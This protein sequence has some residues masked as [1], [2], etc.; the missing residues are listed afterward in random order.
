MQTPAWALDAVLQDKKMNLYNLIKGNKIKTDDT[1]EVKCKYSDDMILIP[2]SGKFEVID[3]KSEA[4]KAISDCQSLDIVERINII[5]RAAD[6]FRLSSQEKKL[7]VALSGKPL[8]LVEKELSGAEDF[9]NDFCSLVGKMYRFHENYLYQE[10]R[11][12]NGEIDYCPP[13]NIYSAFI[14][15]GNLE[16]PAFILAH[17]VISGASGIIKPSRF[18]PITC[19][20]AAETF[21]KAG[22][23][24]GAL[25]VIHW[26]SS[27]DSRKNLAAYLA[28]LTPQRI[29]MGSNANANEILGEIRS[30]DMVF[31][32]GCSKCIVGRDA[33]LDDVADELVESVLS[34]FDCMTTRQV[35][36]DKNICSSL[37]N[38]LKEKFREIGE[39][40][41]RLFK[42]HKT[43]MTGYL[44][45]PRT[46]IGFVDKTAADNVESLK[47]LTLTN[48]IELITGKRIE[49]HLISPYLVVTNNLDL[50]LFGK[51]APYVL[52]VIPVD[53]LDH[54]IECANK[55]ADQLPDK[56]SL[57]TAMHG[58]SNSNLR[59]YL[60]KL[61]TCNVVNHSTNRLNQ[62]L[63]HGKYFLMESLAEKKSVSFLER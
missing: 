60:P 40:T 48:Q 23:P 4:E 27:D 50:T 39:I 61:R 25:N 56:K 53:D 16:E 1:F 29:F 18:D 33:N 10:V 46:L 21:A 9:L 52:T 42:Q 30:G 58:Y 44:M 43:N 28:S 57:I 2:N 11:G 13:N 37:I 49:D 26:N 14:P 12:G 31:S 55:A 8:S 35:Y 59:A 7:I 15:A 34:P 45:D 32:E 20:R 41:E 24:A 47:D 51:E 3:A 54:A 17:S 63:P 62:A 22:Y 38:N 5:K 19:L 6:M 36:I